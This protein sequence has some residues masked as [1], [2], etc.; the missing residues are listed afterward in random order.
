MKVR[1][2]KGSNLIS[3]GFLA[4]ML[5]SASVSLISGCEIS[6]EIPEI[7]YFLNNTWKLD[8]VEVNGVTETDVDLSLYRLRLNDDLTFREVSIKGEET[9][10]TWRLDNNASVLILEYPDE[11]EFGF[12]I[13]ELQIR[14]LTMRVIQ[15]EE[16]IGSLDIKY[17]LIPVKS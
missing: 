1:S 4:L 13:V 17:Y 8:K 6:G 12:I 5:I 7:R 3:L 2:G 11:T 15:S 14:N 9:E 16:K 10:G